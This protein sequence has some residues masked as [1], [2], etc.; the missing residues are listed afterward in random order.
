MSSLIQP[1]FIIGTAIGS[2]T[3]VC[4]SIYIY[5]QLKDLGIF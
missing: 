5:K 3:V 4:V 1:L 2:G